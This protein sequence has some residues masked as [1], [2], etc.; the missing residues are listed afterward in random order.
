MSRLSGPLTPQGPP[1]GVK[2]MADVTQQG[3][4]IS[5]PKQAV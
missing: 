4:S 2:Q 3:H 1:Q 5:Y